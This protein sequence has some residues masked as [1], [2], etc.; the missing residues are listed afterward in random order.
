MF[1]AMQKK[2]GQH[3]S[4]IFEVMEKDPDGK[5]FDKGADS[6]ESP[7]YRSNLSVCQ[8]KKV[9]QSPEYALTAIC[10]RWTSC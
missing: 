2:Q 5:R 1:I 7:S 9:L 3:F 10:T 6:A 4:D 8:T